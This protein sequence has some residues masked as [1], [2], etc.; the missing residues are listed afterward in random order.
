MEPISKYRIS[1]K[2]AVRPGARGMRAQ[3]D[4]F[5]GSQRPE[6]AA[7]AAAKGMR[8]MNHSSRAR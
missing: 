1:E 3:L 4:A 2:D 8:W 7:F 5:R 6:S